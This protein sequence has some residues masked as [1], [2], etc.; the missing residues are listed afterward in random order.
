MELDEAHEWLKEMQSKVESVLLLAQQSTEEKAAALMERQ[1]EL[2]GQLDK[3][4]DQ[5]SGTH[6]NPDSSKQAG[7]AAQ[8]RHRLGNERATWQPNA[9][10]NP[11]P[12]LGHLPETEISIKK[13][14]PP[15]QS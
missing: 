1:K 8:I 15:G 9:N 2:E 3:S 7:K 5:V 14:G 4:R 6:E 10:T 11:A 12:G 13:S